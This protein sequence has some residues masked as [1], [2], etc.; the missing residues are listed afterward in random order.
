MA[1]TVTFAGFEITPDHVRPCQQY[2][3]AIRHF[4]RP[5]NITDMRSWFGLVNQVSY[6]F[7]SA[8][9]MLPFREALKPGSTFLWTDELNQLFEESKAIIVSEIENGVRIFDKSKPTCLATDWSKTGI[10]FWLFQKHCSCPS[11]KPFCCRT[12]WKIT[13]VGSRFTHAAESR[14][15]PIEGEALAVADALDKARFFVLGCE[16]LIVAVDHKPLLK[17]F[18]DRCLEDISN[19]RLC[20][21]KEKTLRYR[22]RMMHIPGVRH[23]A[24]DAMS[25]YPTGPRDLPAYPIPDDIANISQMPEPPVQYFPLHAHP[26]LSHIRQSANTLPPSATSL[27]QEIPSTTMASLRTMAIT[28][29]RVKE[30]TSSDT[31]MLQ[32][33]HLIDTGFPPTRETTPT[34]LQPYYQARDHLSTFDGVV[35]YKHRIVIPTSLRPHVL[36]VLHSAH[37]GVT[38]M[39]SRAESTVFWPGITQD[40]RTR[41]ESCPQCNRMAPSQPNAPPTIMQQPCYPF[42]LLCADYFHYQGVNYLV[43]VDRYSNW[44]I[45]ERAHDGA[46]GLVNTL[47]H[48]FGTYGIPEELATDGGPE[49]TS[50]LTRQFLADWGIHHRL[51]SVAYPH[52]NCRAEVGVKTIKRLITNNTKPNGS[53]DTD[54][55]QRAVLQYRNTPDPSAKLSPAQCL[56]GRPIRDFIPILPGRYKPHPTWQDTLDKRENALRNRHMR[57]AEKWNEHTRRLPP[58]VVGNYVRLQNQTGPYPTKWDKTGRVVEVRQFDQYVVRVD[59]SGRMTVRNR[60]YLRKFDPVLRQPPRRSILSDLI[61]RPDPH[62]TTPFPHTTPPP[63][64]PHPA[65]NQLSY[66]V[67]TDD[68]PTTPSS[69]LSPAPSPQSSPPSTPPTQPSPSPTQPPIPM[70]DLPPAKLPL[71]LRRLQDFNK[72]GLTE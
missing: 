8:E 43:L 2:L 47:R 58:L 66:P 12:G 61:Y 49:F 70:S 38:S 44:P 46:N 72:K 45:V 67:G 55:F 3:D 41:R 23:K 33:L 7:A 9:H 56:F 54:L 60:K 37:Q 16:D 34:E 29:D 42:Q 4:P 52:S 19:T 48:T 15:A 51:S 50:A 26:L 57:S 35:L 69:V 28:W 18:G 39:V 11:R 5:Q 14:Y 32:L 1:L 64:E 22:F 68:T 40:I 71:A 31:N 20:N 62:H 30:A 27:E 63:S 53:L 13:L 59:G 10:G 36:S 65:P 17:V 6:A 24:A 21:L 25:R